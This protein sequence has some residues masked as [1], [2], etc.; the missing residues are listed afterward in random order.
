MDLFEIIQRPTETWNW[1]SF[2]N[3]SAPS[4]DHNIK[5]NVHKWY[6]YSLARDDNNIAV[7]DLDWE[8]APA[9]GA[10]NTKLLTASGATEGSGYKQNTSS[11]K[12]N[13]NNLADGSVNGAA[14]YQGTH[15][16][17][18]YDMKNLRSNDQ[19]TT[20]KYGFLWTDNAMTFIVYK[21]A[22]GTNELYR[23]TV[24]KDDMNFGSESYSNSD[25]F[26]FDQYAYMLIENHIFTAQKD[27]NSWIQAAYDDIGECDLVID[28][29]RIYQLD[30]A[31][32]IIT[33]ESE[34]IHNR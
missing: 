27:G 2:S 25:T 24:T 31:R 16:T 8:N 28:Y 34:S 20:R 1:G 15:A 18:Q 13:T 19:I 6:S 11:I 29:V 3:V 17:M 4:D 5:F 7:Y 9:S 30:G 21:D 23:A 12:I 14:T 33:P 32:A 26:G 10:F 22:T